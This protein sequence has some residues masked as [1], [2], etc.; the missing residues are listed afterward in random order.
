MS[1]TTRTRR[2][3]PH[4][5]PTRKWWAAQITAVTTLATAWVTAGAWNRPLTLAA[6][7]VV[8]QALVV[9]LVPNA[10]PAP[11]PGDQGEPPVT[12]TRRTATA[13]PVPA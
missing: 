12:T 1:T 3:R 6:I 8:S 2:R 11:R 10:D 13:Q 7:G 5:Y 9:Y 4:L